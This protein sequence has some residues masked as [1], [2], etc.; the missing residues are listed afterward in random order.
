MGTGGAELVETLLQ[1]ATLT[2]NK[3]A[4]EGLADMALLFKYLNIFGV[5]NKVIHHLGFFDDEP[6][7]I[8][9]LLHRCHSIS[10]S[11]AA[12]TTTLA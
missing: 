3:S 1:D 5:T 7:L 2:A 6:I 8:P 9:Y 11:L 10:P 12:W 4:K